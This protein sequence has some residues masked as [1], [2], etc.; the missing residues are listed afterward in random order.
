M[1]TTTRNILF[2]LTVFA[3]LLSACKANVS[4]NGDGS[5]DVETSITQQ[6]LQEVISSSIAD[7]LIQNLTVSLQS[8]YILASGTRQRLNDS[9]NT[10]TLSFRL[11]LEASNGEL[12]ATIS[13]AQLDG[14]P[15]E[16][17]RVENWN[18]TITNRIALIGQKNPNST[19]KS[20][21]ITSSE[22]IMIWNVAR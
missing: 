9:S 10:D 2:L 6:E 19:L 14:K 22:V 8:G 13:D 1:K 21:T 4:R 20:V 7:P 15:I 5:L 16:Q 11:D 17:N 18:Q 3:L 12:V